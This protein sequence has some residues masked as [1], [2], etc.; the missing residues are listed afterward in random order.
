MLHAFAH[1][2]DSVITGATQLIIDHNRALDLQ[3][4]I[5]SQFDIGTMPQAMTIMSQST[6]LSS[7]KRSP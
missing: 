4:T 3:S 1:G 6:L 7:A 5:A 2:K